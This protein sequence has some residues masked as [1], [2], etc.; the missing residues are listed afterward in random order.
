[1]S[2]QQR[3]HRPRVRKAQSSDQLAFRSN[4]SNRTRADAIGLRYSTPTLALDVQLPQ[5]QRPLPLTPRPQQQK[6]LPQLPPT[7]CNVT[8]VTPQ[9]V[10]T[11]LSKLLNRSVPMTRDSISELD[12]LQT[13]AQE[14]DDAFARRLQE[15]DSMYRQQDPQRVKHIE[16][17]FNHSVRTV[18]HDDVMMITKKHESRRKFQTGRV[19][20]TERKGKGSGIVIAP[21]QKILDASEKLC[22]QPDAFFVHLR[23]DLCMGEDSFCFVCEQQFESI[24]SP[25]RRDAF[26]SGSGSCMSISSTSDGGGGG[27]GGNTNTTAAKF[28]VHQICCTEQLEQLCDNAL[29]HYYVYRTVK[30]CLPC[31]HKHNNSAGNGT[32]VKIVSITARAEQLYEI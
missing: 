22:K 30:F 17:E 14:D 25:R 23:S 20:N 15:L 7:R 4:N 29:T 8:T 11:R 10:E 26:S 18:D 1:M 31:F 2:E 24:A 5:S 9:S 19:D 16:A 28:Y 6:Q 21:V 12:M 32:A 13:Y 3:H 27:G